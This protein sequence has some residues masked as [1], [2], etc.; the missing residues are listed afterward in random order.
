MQAIKGKSSGGSTPRPS[1]PTV[2]DDTLSSR[3]SARVLCLIGEGEIAGAEGDL[4]KS[5][6]LD[7]T[8]IMNPDGS[9]NFEGCEVDFR[10]GTVDQSPMSGFDSTET[11]TAVG[12]EVKVATGAVTRTLTNESANRVRVRIVVPYLSFTHEDTGNVDESAIEFSIGI[13]T[14]G[15]AYVEHPTGIYGKCTSPYEKNYIFDL[16]TTGPWNIRV[17]RTTPDTDVWFE[18]KGVIFQAFTGIVDNKFA[19][20]YS[21]LLG[22]K[23]DASKFQS[24]PSIG[25]R[26]RG[27]KMQVPSNYDPV[28][29]EYDGFWDGTF[30]ATQYT[31]NPAWVYYNILTNPRYGCGKAIAAD[32]VDIYSLYAIG[33]YC[34]EL[35]SDGLGGEEP[36]FTCNAYI[37]TRGEAYSVL[38]SLAS[39]FRGVVY[40]SEGM[41][42]AVQDRPADPVR[43]Y[44]E[45]NVIQETDED[46]N[47]T[48]PCFSYSGTARRA[49]HTVAIVSYSDPDDFFNTKVEYVEDQE[50]IIRYGYREIEITAFGCASRGQAQRVGRWTLLAEKEQTETVT[51]SVATEGLL[52]RPYEIVTIADP[53]KIGRR[54]GGRISEATTTTVT[55]DAPLVLESGKTYTLSVMDSTGTAVERTVTTSPGTVSSLTVSATF[56]FTPQ[57][58]SVWIVSTETFAPSQYRIIGITENEDGSYQLVG[59]LHQAGRQIG[60][61]V[62]GA[63]GGTITISSRF[64]SIDND[65]QVVPDTSTPLVS[66]SV[67]TVDPDSIFP[68]AIGALLK[69]SWG[70]PLN[71]SGV[72]DSTI[73]SYKIQ[74]RLSGAVAWVDGGSSSTNSI[75]I[76]GVAIGEYEARISA[77]DIYQR[78]S[79]WIA[80]NPLV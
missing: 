30:S 51:F 24:L 46:G 39:V 47:I 56:G 7:R 66:P 65:T 12:V 67:S 63:G 26:G 17:T 37:Q 77:V 36:R 18:K 60:E 41:A 1:S 76:P 44:T 49:R 55:L 52:V 61:Y 74:Y 11:E 21:A 2:A 40:W 64:D 22:V 80:S 35:V 16:S 75:D 29:R 28:T 13:S 38:G 79:A 9:L 57:A 23:F 62:E 58:E 25:F 5:V 48:K 32:Q 53:L 6:Y 59:L 10:F 73:A 69:I 71:S 78:S 27:I 34:D 50:S 68:R 54:M 31:N 4:L 15:G 20:P 33:Q 43:L 42:I 8:P 3:S 45:A 70:L 14:Q 72:T 19:Y